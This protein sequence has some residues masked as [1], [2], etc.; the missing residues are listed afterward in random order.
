MH[1]VESLGSEAQYVSG[2]K[3]PAG[4]MNGKS[5][6]LNS[7]AAQ[8]YPRGCVVPS[9][10]LM[11]ILDADQVRA[12]S[13]PDLKAAAA[14]FHPMKL[15]LRVAFRSCPVVVPPD[16]QLGHSCAGRWTRFL[17]ADHTTLRRR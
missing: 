6:N 14:V 9:S 16:K 15:T 8:M 3:R 5:G 10:E 11:C 12:A 17:F 7:C 1:R 4:E 13:I 2:R